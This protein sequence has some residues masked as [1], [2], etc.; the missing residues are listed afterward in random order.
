MDKPSGVF[1]CVYARAMGNSQLINVTGGDHWGL[2]SF[3][4]NAVDQ[5][6]KSCCDL[7]VKMYLFS[8]NIKKDTRNLADSYRKQIT[9]AFFTIC[10]VSFCHFI[11]FSLSF[12]QNFVCC[13]LFKVKQLNG[14]DTCKR[15]AWII[16]YIQLHMFDFLLSYLMNA[17]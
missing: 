10:A 3:Q 16:I 4:Y 8:G 9:R 2:V 6:I 14:E 12:C 13:C 15:L 7:C 17:S 5:K 11:N 1:Q